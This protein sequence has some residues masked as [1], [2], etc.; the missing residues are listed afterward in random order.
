MLKTKLLI[1]L[2]VILLLVL[3]F[4]SYFRYIYKGETFANPVFESDGNLFSDRGE[5][6]GRAGYFSF[7]PFKGLYNSYLNN[8]TTQHPC[9]TDSD[10]DTGSCST[11]GYCSAQYKNKQSSWT[12][13][14]SI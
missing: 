14:E 10:C 5:F 6:K 2:L 8:T 11:Y 7:F 9:S 12:H 1:I 3:L 13:D 4:L